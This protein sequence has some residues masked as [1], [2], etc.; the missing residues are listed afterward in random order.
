[1]TSDLTRAKVGGLSAEQLNDLAAGIRAR[2]AATTRVI[3]DIGRDLS[4]VKRRLPHGAFTEWV[5]RDCGLTMR[6]AQNYMRATAFV[7][8]KS[9][10]VALLTPASLYRLSAKSTPPAIISAVLEQLEAGHVP[11][12]CEILAMLGG[13]PELPNDTGHKA[14]GVQDDRQSAALLAS[15]ILDRLGPELTHKLIASRWDLVIVCL[16]ELLANEGALPAESGVTP[17][18]ELVRDL[19]NPNLYRPKA[20]SIVA[21]VEAN[22]DETTAVECCP[23]DHSDE[24]SIPAW[25]CRTCQ[26]SCDMND[27]TKGQADKIGEECSS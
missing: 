13:A 20:P 25:L 5:I 8:G 27:R 17:S 12:E 14:T 23:I 1:M 22:S 24:G 9:E 11:T 21:G 10:T 6:S 4:E 2:A 18:V 16:R 3:I 7:D 15:E 26:P 19:H